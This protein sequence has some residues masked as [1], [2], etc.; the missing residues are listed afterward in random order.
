VDDEYPQHFWIR[1]YTELSAENA[2]RNGGAV[3]HIEYPNDETDIHQ[4]PTGKFCHNYDA[5]ILA[6]V[7]A[8]KRLLNIDIG[9][10]LVA[11][12]TD[13]RSVLQALESNK[14][15]DLQVVLYETCRYCK[16]KMQWIPSHCGILGNKS[17]DRLAKAGAAEY[18]PDAPVTYHQK[19]K[20]ITSICKHQYYNEMSTTARVDQSR[21]SSCAFEQDI[22]D[23]ATI[24]THNLRSA[25]QLCAHVNKHHKPLNTF[26]RIALYMKA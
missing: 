24:C 15:P 4:L 6:V 23:S 3:V 21:L 1:V 14:L 5:E 10:H 18:Q 2:V 9:P 22:I 19:K 8:I 17:A 12:L 16:V 13:A 25:T 7:V 26:F 20:M 11:F